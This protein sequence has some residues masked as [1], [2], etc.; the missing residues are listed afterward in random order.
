MIN[1]FVRSW[2]I[3]FSALQGNRAPNVFPFSTNAT[4]R[5]T[6]GVDSSLSFTIEH[7]SSVPHPFG[8]VVVTP[9]PP[10]QIDANGDI[11]DPDIKGHYRFRGYLTTDFLGQK[12]FVVGVFSWNLDGPPAEDPPDTG[13]WVGGA[14][15]P[16]EE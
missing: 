7:G 13:G 4:L 12:P 14:T 6:E 2:S 11:T 8:N 5:I 3:S 10:W 16:P 1:P 15:N 9:G